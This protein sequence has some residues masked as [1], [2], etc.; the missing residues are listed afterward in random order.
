MRIFILIYDEYAVNT[1]YECL[2]SGA[3]SIGTRAGI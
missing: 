1:Y 3:T 2:I